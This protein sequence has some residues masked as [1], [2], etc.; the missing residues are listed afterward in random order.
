MIFLIPTIF[1]LE[2]ISPFGNFTSFDILGKDTTVDS[3]HGSLEI[4]SVQLLLILSL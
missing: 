4:A 3:T 1:A 2:S